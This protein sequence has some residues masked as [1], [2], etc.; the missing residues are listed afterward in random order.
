[1]WTPWLSVQGDVTVGFSVRVGLTVDDS[2]SVMLMILIL[3]VTRG[4]FLTDTRSHSPWA[5][6]VMTV[7]ASACRGG[8]GD[9]L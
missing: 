4:V 8:G 1:M 9:S 7:G 5:P 6:T 2:Q 3:S